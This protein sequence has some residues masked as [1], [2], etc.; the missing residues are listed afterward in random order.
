MNRQQ[1]RAAGHPSRPR[2]Y[3]GLGIS[4]AGSD[5]E[6]A[7]V[8]VGLGTDDGPMRAYT[9]LCGHAAIE[10]A[11]ELREAGELALTEDRLAGHPHGEPDYN[12]DL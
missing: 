6:P 11:N 5:G 9:V 3:E 1:R 2:Y 7:A 12:H 8:V 4:V 10:L